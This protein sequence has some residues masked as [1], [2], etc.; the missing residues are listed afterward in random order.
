MQCNYQLED[1][2]DELPDEV[3][4]QMGRKIISDLQTLMDTT[5]YPED[6]RE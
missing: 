1:A 3:A 4:Q 5:E 6:Y 2:F